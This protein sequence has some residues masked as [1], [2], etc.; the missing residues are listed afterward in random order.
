MFVKDDLGIFLILQQGRDILNHVDGLSPARKQ[1]ESN[2]SNE[3]KK[4]PETLGF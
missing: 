1:T 3:T 2:K 4:D